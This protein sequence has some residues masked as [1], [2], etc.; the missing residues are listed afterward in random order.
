MFSHK[1]VKVFRP[2]GL[3]INRLVRRGETVSNI[4]IATKKIEY[5][6]ELF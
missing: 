6:I 5:R 3:A 4:M 2:D 1:L